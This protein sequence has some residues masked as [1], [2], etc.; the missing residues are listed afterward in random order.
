M[1]H[2]PIK[3]GG[4]LRYSAIPPTP[5]P[6]SIASYTTRTVSI[7]PATACDAHAPPKPQRSDLAAVA[8]TAPYEKKGG[9]QPSDRCGK[10]RQGASYG[11][12]AC[13]LSQFCGNLRQTGLHARKPLARYSAI[14]G[15]AR[16]RLATPCSWHIPRIDRPTNPM[17][18]I[19]RQ[20]G[21]G[22]RATS[23]RNAGRHHLGM[24]GRLRRNPQ[25]S[26]R[27]HQQPP[28]RRHISTVPARPKH[29][30]LR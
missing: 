20:R 5:M 15:R 27:R 17:Q 8:Q 6:F 28:A 3:N 24:P 11:L 4:T 22:P 23:C 16:S 14:W 26:V 2:Y 9:Y 19:I 10:T 18:Q 30:L 29:P 13:A 12:T 25:S 21:A 1:R 7:S